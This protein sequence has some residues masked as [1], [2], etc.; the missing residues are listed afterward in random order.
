VS[1]LKPV[2]EGLVVFGVI[3]VV[4]LVGIVFV[5]SESDRGLALIRAD[6]HADHGVELGLFVV[7]RLVCG[8]AW[9]VAGEVGFVGR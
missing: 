6:V 5:H 9:V 8:V 1:G 3:T 4:P 2:G 7:Y